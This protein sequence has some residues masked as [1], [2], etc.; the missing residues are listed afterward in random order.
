[1]D[2]MN[3][4]QQRVNKLQSHIRATKIP[5]GQ[6]S[7]SEIRFGMLARPDST[8]SGLT[9]AD[10]FHEL[11][12][13]SAARSTA[14]IFRLALHIHVARILHDPLTTGGCS[15]EVRSWVTEALELLPQVP[16]TI[17]P[18]IFL[19][20]ALVVIGAELDA[21]DERSHIRRRLESLDLLA[22]NQGKTA[23]RVLD[24][25]WR[26]RDLIKCG[27]TADKRAKWQEII[28]DMKVDL[29]LM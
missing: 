3:D 19:G 24:E 4:I 1:M 15:S 2:V 16:D 21:L 23:L 12:T 22:L 10:A 14:E 8:A 11:E 6:S 26:R 17:G 27:N 28:L 25:V 7:V 13:R 20:W 18:G 5:S 29:A 9:L